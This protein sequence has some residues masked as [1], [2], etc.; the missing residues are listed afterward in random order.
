MAEQAQAIADMQHQIQVLAQQNQQQEQLLQQQGQQLQNLPAQAP[1]RAN[2]KGQTF[3]DPET[4][5]WKTFRAQVEVLPQANAWTIYQAKT[6]LINALR[7]P[8]AAAAVDLPIW[9]NDVDV[10]GALDILE[11]KFLPRAASQIAKSQFDAS[12]QQPKESLMAWH[13][14]VQALH[15]K[16]YPG[17]NEESN[18]IR[19]FATGIKVSQVCS[20]V[21]RADP[22]TFAEALTSAQ[23]EFGVMVMDRESGGAGMRQSRGTPMEI[24]AIPDMGPTGNE[25]T[26]KQIMAILKN[27]SAG[28]KDFACF[29]CGDKNHYKS[30][31]S[32]WQKAKEQLGKKDS[33]TTSRDRAALTKTVSPGYGKPRSKDG[34][35]QA[36]CRRTVAGVDGDILQDLEDEEDE[37]E[38]VDQDE[39]DEEDDPDFC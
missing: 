5:D 31:C 8:A 35:F 1:P 25:E 27:Q 39:E 38:E 18:M 36:G 19:K 12:Y 21:F 2:L 10:A 29:F 34:K 24:G 11:E 6:A 16:A 4:A 33:G 14:R 23:N 9:P 20:Q 3:E 37:D 32:L 17:I 22:L 28:G 13:T 7:G 30:G 26:K 15:R